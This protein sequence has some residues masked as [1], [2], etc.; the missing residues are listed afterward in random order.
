M[1][2]DKEGR[3]DGINTPDFTFEKKTSCL[4][5]T[6]KSFRNSNTLAWLKGLLVMDNLDYGET[7]ELSVELYMEGYCRHSLSTQ[8]GRTSIP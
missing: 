5:T 4:T 1:S 8:Y 2:P 6:K 3:K 7:V